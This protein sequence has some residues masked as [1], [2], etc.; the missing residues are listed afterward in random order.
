MAS[1]RIRFIQSSMIGQPSAG[2]GLLE[3]VTHGSLLV[4]ESCF[5]LYTR[6]IYCCLELCYE[7]TSIKPSVRYSRL[8]VA[9]DPVGNMVWQLLDVDVLLRHYAPA[10]RQLLW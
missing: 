9:I 2:A 3:I 4:K 7:P 6:W 10:D 8:C 1:D 5:C